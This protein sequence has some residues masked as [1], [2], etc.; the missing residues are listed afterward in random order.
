MLAGR[1]SL[2]VMAQWLVCLPRRSVQATYELIHGN[3][4][5]TLELDDRRKQRSKM[6]CA[7]VLFQTMCAAIVSACATDILPQYD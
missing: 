3:S 4:S 2:L 1:S 7:L 5:M 6:L